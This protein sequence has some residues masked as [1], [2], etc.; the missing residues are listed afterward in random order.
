MNSQTQRKRTLFQRFCAS[1]GLNILLTIFAVWLTFS[2]IHRWCGY[3][4]FYSVLLCFVAS[5]LLAHIVFMPLV[6]IPFAIY[7]AR[8][9]R[10]ECPICHERGLVVGILMSEPTA[11]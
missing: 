2:T 5:L 11:D 7:S 6:F 3:D 10:S 1:G 4:W 8:F 9:R